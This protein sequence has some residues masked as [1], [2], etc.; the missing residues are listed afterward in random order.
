MFGF[1]TPEAAAAAD[2][3]LYLGLSGTHAIMTYIFVYYIVI[4]RLTLALM[5]S[6][7][8]RVL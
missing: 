5:R 6:A 7:K 8:C 1:C 3:F 2:P 4:P